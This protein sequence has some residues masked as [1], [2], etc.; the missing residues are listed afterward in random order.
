MSSSLLVPVTTIE[1]ILP[2][3]NA[4]S[5]ELAQVLGWQLV[6]RRG[7]YQ[8]GDRIV[9][10]PIDTVLP[11]ELSEKFGVTKYL[12]KQR[13]KCARLRGEPS[14]GL[15]IRPEQ[16]WEIGENV[17]EYYHVEKYNPPVRA[18]ANDAEVD[19]PL[20][21]K[22]TDI[23]N[24][25]N[26]PDVF[27]VGEMVSLTEKIHGSNDRVGWIEGQYM[28]GSHKLRRK[29]PENYASN[30][31]WY[32]LSLAPVQALLT[33]LAG[34]GYRQVILYGEIYGPGVQSLQYGQK[35]LGYRVFDIMTDGC[36]VDTTVMR[37]I[38][39]DF[40][41]ETVPELARIPYSLEAVKS[42]SDGKTTLM[43]DGAHMREGVVVKP[44]QE[45]IDPKIGRCVLKYVG[46]TY[47]FGEK[48]DYQEV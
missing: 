26:F 20:F 8:E 36:Y 6:V 17:A 34:H 44:L 12:S 10:F 13:I 40:E 3:N 37:D 27:Q 23:E 29:E 43:T 16:E 35:G 1:K 7:E 25:R 28:A 4:D 18:T 39:E 41:V 46:D 19:H 21:T 2:H 15:A 9:Y 24:M 22:Y 33:H 31:Y 5:L 48:S 11:L 42:Y 45:R 30:L 32:P 38:C 47:L 14:F